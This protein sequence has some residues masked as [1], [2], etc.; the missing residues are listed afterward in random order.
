MRPSQVN[1]MNNSFIEHIIQRTLGMDSETPESVI[2]PDL[3]PNFEPHD[4]KI[5]PL[6]NRLFEPNEQYVD[7]FYEPSDS[8]SAQNTE[9]HQLEK[10]KPESKTM[11]LP[12]D[13]LKNVKENIVD[14]STKETP[15]FT[16]LNKPL[17]ESSQKNNVIEKPEQVKIDKVEKLIQEKKIIIDKLST[18]PSDLKQKIT[19]TKT[20][21]QKK[22]ITLEN[23]VLENTKK[24]DEHSTIY[25][26]KNLDSKKPDNSLINDKNVVQS[27]EK[28]NFVTYLNEITKKNITTNAVQI[29]ENKTNVV[30]SDA[31]K[32]PERKS[33]NSDMP[34]FS[35][36]NKPEIDNLQV[37]PSI[38][39][40]PSNIASPINDN[41]SNPYAENLEKNN[42][43]TVT[44]NIDKIEVKV[45]LPQ[46]AKNNILTKS[47]RMSLSEYLQLRREGKL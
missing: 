27:I 18:S 30:K 10:N 1:K 32:I 17:D 38:V 12:D 7:S 15:T 33:D 41:P 46:Q 44:I 21:S 6:T 34:Q 8:I 25:D 3:A 39:I 24:S 43:N 22:E 2:T 9:P 36:K 23:S 31:N 40:E 14:P 29:N 28:N 11:S 37:S 13:V 20:K 47:N 16:D 42:S 4:P 5:N 45:N 35:S 26:G 19:E